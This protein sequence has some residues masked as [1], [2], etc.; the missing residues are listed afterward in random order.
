MDKS[1][2]PED[3]I[4]IGK[5]ISVDG[6]LI[7]VR[8]DKT[9]NTSHLLYKGKLLKNI[10]VG[11]DVRFQLGGVAIRVGASVRI[12]AHIGEEQF[13]MSGALGALDA[14]SGSGNE[15]RVALVE[16][17][18]FQEQKNVVLYPLLQVPNGEQDRLALAPAPFHSS[19]K[20]LASACSCCAG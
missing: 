12:A 8:V 19:R 1:E 9:K 17:R 10:S 13:V 20:Q 16:R 6:R 11:L 15:L 4:K 14:A 5:V 18:L 2:T 7:R 3:A